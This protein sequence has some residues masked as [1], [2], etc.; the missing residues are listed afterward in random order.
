MTYKV[1]IVDDS[2]VVRT[3]L[4]EVLGAD[5]E[6]EVIGTASNPYE[7]V[8]VMRGGMPDVI[9]LD[10]EMPRMD[11]LT[12]LEK[13]MAQHPVPV[14]ICS[15][16]TE[17]GSQE[18]LR[19]LEIGAVDIITKPKLGARA[20]FAE[21]RVTLCDA[22]RAAAQVKKLRPAPRTA[23]PR[24]ATRAPRPSRLRTTEKL[25]VLGASTGGTE[26][27]R[28]VLESL[29]QDAP[30]VA[31]VQH[32]PAG[33]TAAFAQRLDGLLP[34]EVREA[35][36]GDGLLRG[37]VLVA[38]GDRHLLVR[39]NG[40]RYEAELRE[41]PLV[42]RHRPSVDV[43]FRSAARAAGANVVAA[44]LTGMG[45]DGA[46]GIRD[47]AEAGAMTVAQ[48]EATS[49]VFGMPGAAI[50]AGGVKE[51]LPLDAVGARLLELAEGETSRAAG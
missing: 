1:L 49:V 14:V 32:M 12:F 35:R 10:I 15:T 43:L 40:A 44:I 37:R 19:A 22:V 8:E 11:G 39:R 23:A 6:L 33:F 47:L 42:S 9:T 3:A 45:K 38:P 30:A 20:F 4:S 29:P 5:P 48:D 25:I 28:V 50:A 51:V 34:L 21:A 18:T 13:I 31:V 41:G 46:R 2:A 17:R 16:L 26:A 36:D 27:L 7:A 24:P